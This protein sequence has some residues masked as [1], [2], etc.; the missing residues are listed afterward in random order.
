MAQRI[1]ATSKTLIAHKNFEKANIGYINH[2]IDWR[3]SL[4]L[5]NTVV[6]NTGMYIIH[7]VAYLHFTMDP[8]D[9][10]SGATFTRILKLCQKR[11][12]CSPRFLRTVL[13]VLMLTGQ[14]IAQRS[15]AD[16]RVTVY[17]PSDNLLHA[18]RRV[19]SKT[20][21]CLDVILETDIYENYALEDPAF[22]RDYMNRAGRRVVDNDIVF[23]ESGKRDCRSPSSPRRACRRRAQ[24]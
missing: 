22:F 2:L 19:I 6:S 1:S 21:A 12:D 20:F 18:M 3:Q 10:E 23:S 11:D 8:T 13:G 5:L 14:I 15:P 4:G 7:Y 16:K 9:P 17:A 24:G